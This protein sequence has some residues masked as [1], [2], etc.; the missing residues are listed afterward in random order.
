MW[1]GEL[2]FGDLEGFE[3]AGLLFPVRMPGGEAAIRQPW[4]MACA[5]LAAAF[6]EP[7]R[8][9]RQLARQVD[10]AVV[11]PG[12]EAR[13]QRALLAAHHQRRAG[14]STRWR[15]SAGCGRRST[16]RARPRWSWRRRAIPASGAPT[17][18]RCSTIGGPLVIDARPTVR[19]VVG[20][21]EAGVE[22][23]NDRGALPQ[24]AGRRPPHARAR[25]RPSAG[26]PTSSCSR[27][28]CSRTAGWSGRP[29]RCSTD[30]GLRVLTP[31]RLPPND[32]GIAYGQLAVA[33]ARLAAEDGGADV[34]T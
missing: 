10:A 25:W 21:L 8:P 1:G 34:R 22:V 26:A 20:D 33:A 15:P 19:A 7:R 11:G 3:R 13:D 17:S 23:G 2:L 30:A 16:T 31:E 29:R 12:V 5:W 6:D 18:C 32:G 14:C 24:R 9:P 4:R 27:E 28:G